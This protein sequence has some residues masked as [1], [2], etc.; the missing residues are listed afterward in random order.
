LK[1]RMK[2]K[3]IRWKKMRKDEFRWFKKPGADVY[4]TDKSG[5]M[6]RQ[7]SISAFLKKQKENTERSESLKGN[8]GVVVIDTDQE[9]DKT[10]VDENVDADFDTLD[11]QV[12]PLR[13]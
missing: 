2:K 9:V 12:S 4:L 11:S 10:K 7:S 13:M 6:M 3:E 8:E 1:S 5:K